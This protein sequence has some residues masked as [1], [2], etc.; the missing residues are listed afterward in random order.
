MSSIPLKYS[1]IQ[2]KGRLSYG[3]YMAAGNITSSVVK[4][5][6][7]GNDS[8]TSIAEDNGG[9]GKDKNKNFYMFLSKE[10][11]VFDAQ[12]LAISAQ[13][14]TI[15]VIGYKENNRVPTYVMALDQ[16]EIVYDN[17]TGAASLTPPANSG[18]TGIPANGMAITV[19]NNGTTA[20]TI[21][22]IVDSTIQ[23][24]GG[25]ITIPCNVYL[26]EES[27]MG[28]EVEKWY[29]RQSDCERLDFIYSYTI[30][31]GSPS[32]SYVLELTNDSAGINC[33]LNGNVLTGATRPTCKATLYFGLDPVSGATF[34]L[35]T[36]Q[37]AAASGVSINTSTG[38]LT[39]GNNF[40]FVGTTLEISVSASYLG[41]TLTKIMSVSKNYP[42]LDGTGATTRWI[43]PSV[44]TIKVDPNTGTIVPTGVTATVMKQVNDQE[45][46]IDNSTP[47][48]YGWDTETPL[49]VYS[50]PIMVVAAYDYLALGLKNSGGTFYELETIPILEEGLNG[51]AGTSGQSVYRLDLSNEN[52]SINCDIDGNLLPGAVRPQCKATLYYGSSVVSGAVYSLGANYGTAITINSST[53]EITVGNAFTW[54]GTSIG[55]EIKATVNNILRGTATFS[56]SKNY[57]GDDGSP[58]VA[59]WLSP[60]A[61]AIQVDSG[62]TT[63]PS[64]I[65]CEAYKQ[66]GEQTPV[67]LSSGTTPYI[68]WGYNTNDPSTRYSGQTITV[69]NTKK[70]I[71]FQLWHNS[72]QYD[73]E[74][75]PILH[76]GKNGEGLPGRQGAAIRGPVE[77]LST[78][79]R[80][81]CSGN[82]NASG[83]SLEEDYKWLDIVF[84]M[85]G[86]TKVYYVCNTSYTQA[87]NTS[88][89][90]VSQ[91]WTQTNDQFEFVAS[92]VILA[93]NAYIDFLTSNG[94]YLRD[95]NGN[96]VGG[97]Q[98]S[99]TGNTSGSSIIFWAGGDIENESVNFT[100]DYNGN[101]FANSGVFR[102]YI[103]MPFTNIEQLE[104][105]TGATVVVNDVYYADTRAYLISYPSLRDNKKELILPEPNSGLNGFTY[106]IIIHPVL[107]RMDRPASLLMSASGGTDIYCYAFAE[108]KVG[109]QFNLVAGKFTI[110][111]I[112]SNDYSH[113]YR[114][115]IISCSGNLE[116]V[117]NNYSTYISTLLAESQEPYGMINKILTYSGSTQPSTVNS[118]NTMYVKK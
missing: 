104:H 52:A 80:R 22:V 30:E 1:T 106:E 60:S 51:P 111:C 9:E 3:H 16:V 2:P 116:V 54:T 20:T 24:E 59:Y 112:P 92:K 25:E 17:T 33:D 62:G 32:S 81:W 14:D 79:A 72:V 85:S 61:N 98:A 108:L 113:P 109:E 36:P 5:T 19:S 56:L 38:V 99:T 89:N 11:E 28:P 75:I 64:Q 57:P 15:Q 13:T 53:G 93:E 107:S 27:E 78:S 37:E 43:V 77:W 90:A 65:K 58:A 48:Y 68:Y 86:N 6:Y 69:D 47:I 29:P 66:V 49:N 101:I 18:I 105:T 96:I 74:I 63:S 110:T 21:T 95:A 114:W 100:V 94:M 87:A 40:N 55:I 44:T 102:G 10:S 76:D 83:S 34:G 39:F 4:T 41:H 115:A 97:A 35:T 103:Q 12:K 7:Y 42:G 88:W 67:K 31:R 91:Y 118:D 73:I 8:T 117:Y 71:C 70:Y 26:S 50:G 23:G 84:R 82:G 46:E 45:P